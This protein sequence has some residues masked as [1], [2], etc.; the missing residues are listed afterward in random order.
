MEG[1]KHPMGEA[2]RW[3]RLAVR[4][5][6]AWR[7]RHLL[8]LGSVVRR[9]TIKSI[10]HDVLNVGQSVAYS[11][12]VSLFPALIVAAAVAE[13]LPFGA[14]LQFQLA[15][16]FGRVL[17]SDVVPLLQ[18]YFAAHPKNPQSTRAILLAALV[19]I[20]GASSVIATLMEG[21]RRAY[22]LPQDCWSFWQ[23]RR[24]AFALVP[25]SLLPFG[26]ASLLVVFGHV[27]T[28][29]FVGYLTPSIQTPVYVV[30]MAIRWAIALLGSTGVIALIY[31]MGTPMRQVWHRTLPGAVVATGMWFVT[32]LI[33]GWYVTRY[34]DYGR[35]Y[36]S[37][38]AG[39]ALLFWLYLVALCVLCGAEFNA[40]FFTDKTQRP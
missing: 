22:D 21:F 6:S 24:R 18:T 17:P 4:T 36:G 10:E 19:S 38:G 14:S 8:W 28:R 32:T 7:V 5:V 20:S 30:A 2:A 37:L 35:V 16:F 40:Q 13:L 15:H 25:L 29:W 12:M 26:V 23:R 9:T 1:L 34:A 31:H 3:L 11:A 33:F 39:I 27:F